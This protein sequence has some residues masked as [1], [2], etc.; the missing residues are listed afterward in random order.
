MRK[1][2]AYLFRYQQVSFQANSRYLEALAVVHDPNESQTRSG[3]RHDH[4]L[5]GFTNRDIRQRLASTPHL[6]KCGQDPKKAM[7]RSAESS[8]ASLL[9]IGSL[10]SR[11][12]AAGAS[13]FMAD[14]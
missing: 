1:G 9:I 10:R 7:L 12:H 14:A 6:Q 8:D 5:R 11:A 3:R 4:C 13:P 2:V